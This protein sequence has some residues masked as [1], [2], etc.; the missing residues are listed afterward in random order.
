MA[1]ARPL[2]ASHPRGP[3]LARAAGREFDP[4][5]RKA[6]PPTRPPE[7][8]FPQV[9][10]EAP[11]GLAARG[12]NPVNP[13][14]SNGRFVRI[15]AQLS[16]RPASRQPD[17]PSGRERAYASARDLARQSASRSRPTSSRAA[18]PPPTPSRMCCGRP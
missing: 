7:G 1:D 3:H 16:G 4:S 2:I 18:G 13:V 5:D 6:H 14:E 9:P 15:A 8:R 10:P 11:H 17:S 12:S